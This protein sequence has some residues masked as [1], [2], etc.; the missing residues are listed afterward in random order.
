MKRFLVPAVAG[1]AVFGAV[2]GFA[3]TLNV[4]SDTLGAG[5]KVVASCNATASVKYTTAFVTGSYKV[6]TVPVTTAATCKGLDYKVTLTGATSNV[7]GE[8][9]GTLSATDGSTTLD[10]A[11]LAIPAASVTGVSIVLSGTV[12]P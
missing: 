9:T 7:L 11:S 5:D 4:N 2:T 3:A 10:V 1:V 6:A 12:A 8:K